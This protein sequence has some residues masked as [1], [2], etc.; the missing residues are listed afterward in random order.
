MTKM[1]LRLLISLSL[2]SGRSAT[3]LSSNIFTHMDIVD[4]IRPKNAPFLVITYDAD[5]HIAT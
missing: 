3:L 4:E 5:A 1:T 2:V